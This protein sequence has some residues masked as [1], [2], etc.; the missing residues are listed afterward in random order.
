MVDKKCDTVGCNSRG[1]QM[2]QIVPAT[3][4]WLCIFCVLHADIKLGKKKIDNV[5]VM[6]NFTVVH[7]SVVA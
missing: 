2:Y 1:E 4:I 7:T 5:E 6:D 3:S